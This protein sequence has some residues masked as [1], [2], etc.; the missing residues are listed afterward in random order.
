MRYVHHSHASRTTNNYLGFHCSPGLA[1]DGP[2]AARAREVG[3]FGLGGVN[4]RGGARG[5]GRGGGEP[6]HAGVVA[7][8]LRFVCVLC[9]W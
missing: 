1:G 3:R 8:R 6:R 5:R 2:G 9:A 7:L 4:G